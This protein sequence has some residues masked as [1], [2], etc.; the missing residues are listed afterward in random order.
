MPSSSAVSQATVDSN[1]P[2]RA[3][4]ERPGGTTPDVTSDTQAE[5]SA[6]NGPASSPTEAISDSGN[7]ASPSGG[8]HD[9]GGASNSNSWKTSGSRMSSPS[10][11]TTR[12]NGDV[13]PKLTACHPEA[14]GRL[15]VLER[16]RR[17][18]RH[19]TLDDQEA[20]ARSIRDQDSF[21]VCRHAATVRCP[22]LVVQPLSSVSISDRRQRPVDELAD[23]ALVVGPLGVRRRGEPATAALRDDVA[24]LGDRHREV[25]RAL[26]AAGPTGLGV[27]GADRASPGRIG[28]AVLDQHGGELLGRVGKAG[29]VEVEDAQS[30]ALHPPQVVGPEVAVTGPERARRCPQERLERDEVR[31]EGRQ[32]VRERRMSLAERPDDPR[33]NAAS[34]AGTWRAPKVPT[35]SAYRGRGSNT[36]TAVS[37][38]RRA[39]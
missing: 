17:Q 35:L 22:G 7:Q 37:R 4:S 16:P 3:H 23:P 29:V 18:R 20:R 21:H 6:L 5:T 19:V 38:D 28:P 24:E 9:T 25:R 31:D 2:G 36:T 10:S 13:T 15:R 34:S 11:R 26:D 39:A 8:S 12:R 14:V 32:L 1:Q 30:A 33:S 27:G